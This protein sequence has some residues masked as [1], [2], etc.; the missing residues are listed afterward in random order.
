MSAVRRSRPVSKQRAL[1][2]SLME[3]ALKGDPRAMDTLLALH[4]RIVP[5]RPETPGVNVMEVKFV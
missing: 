4:A 2:K 3:K 1:I 5:E